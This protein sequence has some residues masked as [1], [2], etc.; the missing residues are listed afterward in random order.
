M[1]FIISPTTGIDHIDAIFL[2]D[3]RIKIIHLKNEIK[4]LNNITS[5]AET[6]WALLL[7]LSRNIIKYSHDVSY[8]KIWNRNSYI[9]N[10]LKSNTLGI[11]GY[12]RIGKMIARYAKAFGMNINVFEIDK[13]KHTKTKQINFVNLEK[14]LKCKY[15]TIH[16]PLHKNKNFFTKKIILKINKDSILINTSRGD[17]FDKKIMI[18]LLKKNYKLG[19]DVLP[20][21]V[22]WGKKVPKEFHFI[23][24][25]KNTII[26]PHIGGNTYEARIKTTNFI[27]DKFLKVEKKI[28]FT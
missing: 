17:I 8:K 21:D 1:R 18:N 2:K 25:L 23:K 14:V 19:L 10:D 9:G 6:T 20:G 16:I 13:K 11:I 24:N 7:C 5:T 22:I 27:I 4:F 28:N 15:I 26:T 3:K 12:G